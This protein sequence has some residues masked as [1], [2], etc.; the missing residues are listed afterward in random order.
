MSQVHVYMD[1]SGDL[2]FDFAKAKTSQWFVVTFLFTRLPNKLD[3]AVGKVFASFT[4]TEVKNHHG[5]LHAFKE[6]PVTRFRLLRYI[7]MQD[8]HILTIRLDK[9]NVYTNL[10][11]E[12]HVLYN[13]VVNIL[14]DRMLKKNSFIR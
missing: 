2:G 10:Q 12:K 3:K 13:Y 11:N 7:N 9:R 6:R 1:E 14:L 8:V 4:K 5:T